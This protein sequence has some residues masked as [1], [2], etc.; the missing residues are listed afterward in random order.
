MGRIYG[1]MLYEAVI[2]A[3]IAW[4]LGYFI[5]GIIHWHDEKKA[6]SIAAA[7]SAAGLA[8]ED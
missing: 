6:Q 1:A 4:V 3:L 7:R 5:L 2:A 8:Q